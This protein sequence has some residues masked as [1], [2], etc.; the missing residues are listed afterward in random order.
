MGHHKFNAFRFNFDEFGKAVDDL[1][2]NIKVNDIFGADFTKTAPAINVY[3][4]LGYL[5]IQV[6]APGLKKEDFHL[7]IEQDVLTISANAN[8]KELPE[9][10]KTK[11]NEF[12]YSTFKRTFRLNDKFDYQ[13]IKARYE[14]GVLNITIPEK[15]QEPRTTIKV[16]IL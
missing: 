16:D 1:M 8:V 2:Q 15:E 9:D 14:Q 12:N 10:V 11:R 3:E 6:A 4:H 7:Q 13:G 5:E